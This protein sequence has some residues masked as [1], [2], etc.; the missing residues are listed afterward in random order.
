MPNHL[1]ERIVELSIAAKGKP[2]EVHVLDDQKS[3]PT[4]AEL[5]P[6]LFSRYIWSVEPGPGGPNVYAN[7]HVGTSNDESNPITQ[8]AYAT[9]TQF[10][11][12][13]AL[14]HQEDQA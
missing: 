10:A 7:M 5:T 1:N 14:S 12:I 4:D 6:F 2:L 8:V 9:P 3:L 11:R 13:V